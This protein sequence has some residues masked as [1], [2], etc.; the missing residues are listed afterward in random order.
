MKYLLDWRPQVE[1]VFVKEKGKD[2]QTKI[3]NL[4]EFIAIKGVKAKGNRLSSK[5][6]KEINKC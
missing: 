5:K 6:I 1:L 2:R 4:E 3:I